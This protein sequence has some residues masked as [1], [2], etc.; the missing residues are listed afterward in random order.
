MKT[1]IAYAL[2]YPTKNADGTIALGKDGNGSTVNGNQ[3]PQ[4]DT[5]ISILNPYDWA[6][7]ARFEFFNQSGIPQAWGDGLIYRDFLLESGDSLATT[8]IPANV[9]P[10][11]PQD[12]IGHATV[13]FWSNLFGR[14]DPVECQTRAM[15]CG[16][17]FFPGSWNKGGA[18]VP[19]SK[20]EVPLKTTWRCPYSIPF[21]E[22][23]NHGTFTYSRTCPL[24]PWLN[25]PVYEDDSY[26][27]GLV[28]TNFDTKDTTCNVTF[29]VGRTYPGERD[30]FVFN[31]FIGAGQT[32]VCDLYDSLRAVGYAPWRNTEG[33][34]QL[35]T[36][37]PTRL[38]PYLLAANAT[39]DQW[40]VGLDFE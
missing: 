27:T 33:S 17:R 35:V 4:Y 25:G 20:G 19:V 16:G 24:H 15:I 7:T 6:V 38:M 28:I 40:S 36:P 26:R 11:P 32:Y 10:D 21:F 29:R 31:V 30:T 37:T 13:D 2:H 1:Y 22:D 9:F 18:H 23:Y 14:P 39:Y 5:L 12:F 34:I 3:R 8:L